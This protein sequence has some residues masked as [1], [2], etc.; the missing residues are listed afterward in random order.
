MPYHRPHRRTGLAST[1]S[2]GPGGPTRS[3]TSTTR[4]HR[5]HAGVRG[6]VHTSRLGVGLVFALLLL[7]AA[8][9]PATDAGPSAAAPQTTPATPAAPQ[10]A[11]TTAVEADLVIA[12]SAPA[13]GLDPRLRIDPMSLQRMLIVLEPL[14]TLDAELGLQPRLATAWEVADEGRRVTLHLRD[15]VTFHDGWRFTSADVRFTIETGG[16]P[17][18]QGA[19]RLVANLVDRVETPDDRTVVLH[20]VEPAG[21]VLFDLAR[22]PIVPTNAAEDFD[23]NPVGT[24]PYVFEFGTPANV[25][26]FRR[27]DGYWGDHTGPERVAFQVVAR[28]EDVASALLAGRVQLSQRALDAPDRSRLEAASSVTVDVV[29]NANPTYLGFDTSASPLD[30]ARVRRALATLVPRDRIA[31]EVLPGAAAPSATMVPPVAAWAVGADAA[32]AGGRAAAEALLAETDATFDRPLVLLTNANPVREAMAARI[33]DAFEEVGI[34][35]RIETADF[36]SY[37]GRLDAGD[38]DMFL[39]G[40]AGSGN[41]ARSIEMGGLNYEGFEDA[42][43]TDLLARAA[44]FDP[45]SDAGVA[46]YAESLAAFLE[47]SPR[48]YLVLGLN[49]GA[50]ASNVAGWTPHPLDLHAFQDLHRLEVR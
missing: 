11:A 5:T 38:F 10:R 34:E 46:L 30:D 22:M 4:S 14:V 44:Q 36:S 12:V 39:L 8:C 20:L 7:A 50:S 23:E 19:V 27:F 21:H 3:S 42:G 28:S 48:A 43:V 45:T 2:H 25:Q 1:R 15:D 47:A 16:G 37:L 32:L 26:S 18:R 6:S 31:A 9:A 24:G 49:V 41:P 33:R 40:T 29:P 17:D 35:V 13:Q